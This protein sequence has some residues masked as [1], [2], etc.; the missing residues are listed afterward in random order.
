MRL[1]RRK[2]DAEL[3]EQ[4]IDRQQGP[5]Q[6]GG[7]RR[8]TKHRRSASAERGRAWR[9][10][11]YFIAVLLACGGAVAFLVGS[12]YRSLVRSIQA[13]A[14]KP[15]ETGAPNGAVIGRPSVID[16]DTLEVRGQRIR[17]WGI[18]APESAQLC[19]RDGQAWRCGQAAAVALAEWIGE[20]TTSC[21]QKDIDRYRRIV[22]RCLVGG[23]D[24]SAW[25]VQNGWA[26]AF[27]RY[28]MDY[29]VDEDRARRLR[30]GIWDSEFMAPWEWRASRRALDR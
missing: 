23:T 14:S 25:L 8:T 10:R 28:S 4:I 24:V 17:L 2:S 29:V 12:D 18:D 22:G 16:A 30:A 3:L 6:A 13:V 1:F 26:M 27:R 20:R 9:L 19:Q 7:E 11:T 5:R 15:L 21:E